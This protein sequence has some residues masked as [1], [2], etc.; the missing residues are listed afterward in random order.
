MRIQG[1]IRGRVVQEWGIAAC[2][3]SHVAM[4]MG[5]PMI[6]KPILRRIEVYFMILF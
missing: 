6:I 5:L 1:P 4:L 2:P 3:H